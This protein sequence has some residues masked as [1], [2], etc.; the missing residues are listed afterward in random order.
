MA[1]VNPVNWAVLVARSSG[2]R[3][4]DWTLVLTRLG[5]LA[6]LLLLATVL[7]T[8]AFRAYQHSI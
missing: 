3:H 7:A 4:T 2:S 8:R 5:L 1:R 6:G